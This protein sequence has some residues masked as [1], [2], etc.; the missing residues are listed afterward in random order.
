MC[1]YVYTYIQ[2]LLTSFIYGTTP[3]PFGDLIIIRFVST[4][5]TVAKEMWSELR[6][7]VLIMKDAIKPTMIG[8]TWRHTVIH[9]NIRMY[10]YIY[11]YIYIHMYIYIY[12]IMCISPTI[13]LDVCVCVWK[14]LIVRLF[15]R[16]VPALLV[17]W[18]CQQS[19]LL[20]KRMSCSTLWN[21][22]GSVLGHL[23]LFCYVLLNKYPHVTLWIYFSIH[24]VDKVNIYTVLNFHS[25]FIYTGWWLGHPSEKYERQL[26]W[27]A[28]QYMGK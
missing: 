5:A 24:I 2:K 6:M 17:P 11:L 21:Y 8:I 19:I 9:T 3:H 15:L 26:G 27:L 7:H 28:T 20:A 16:T 22:Q 4:A 1:I 23:W 13:I 25:M 10:V 12:M 14:L 18:K